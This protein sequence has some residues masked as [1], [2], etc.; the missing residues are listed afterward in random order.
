MKN[1]KEYLQNNKMSSPI[2]ESNYVKCA[3]QITTTFD[4]NKNEI[5]IGMA[6]KKQRIFT[7][8]SEGGIENI[9]ILKILNNL[10]TAALKFQI[11]TVQWPKSDLFFTFTSIENVREKYLQQHRKLKIAL[12]SPITHLSD[13]SQHETILKEAHINSQTNHHYSRT[14]TLQRVQ[15]KFYW[16]SITLHATIFVKSCEVCKESNK[17]KK[18]Q[19][20][21]S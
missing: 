10:D 20:Q 8:I 7:L 13:P 18:Q 19:F 16:P 1:K 5:L 2:Y 9:D 12:T 21:K 4:T 11:K 6:N 17:T 14:K 15:S 3:H